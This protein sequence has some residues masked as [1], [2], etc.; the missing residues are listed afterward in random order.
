[1]ANFLNAAFVAGVAVV[2]AAALKL[3]SVTM[4]ALLVV[5]AILAASL[6]A[7]GSRAV[8]FLGQDEQLRVEGFMGVSVRNGPGMKVLNPFSYRSAQV[9]KAES[10]G[11]MDYVKVRDTMTGSERIEQGPRLLFLEPYDQVASRSQAIC[12][13]STD[14]VFVDDKLSG[15]RRVVQGP[16]MWFPGPH[17]Q[18]K[19]GSA[20]SLSRTEYIVV[21]DRLKG[22]RSTVRGPTVWFPG[23]FDVASTK[24]TAIALQEDE[25][26]RLKDCSS[27][28]RWVQK[29]KALV[30]LEPTWQIEGSSSKD[31]GVRKAWSL[32]AYEFIRLVDS[33]TGKVS[34]HRGEM[35][36][37]PGPDEELLD[38]A[39]MNA[40]DLKVQE[41]VKILDQA[42]GEVRVERGRASGSTQV[43]LGPNDKIL[44]GGKK[45]AIEV[46]QDH[47]VLVRDKASGQLRLVTEKAL[48][49]PGPNE[50]IEEV[51][52]LIKLSDHE[53]LIVKDKEGQYNFYYG[54]DEKRG[55]DTPRSFFLPPFAEIVT[56][57]WS[58]GRRRETRDLKISR[59][60]CRAQ[61]MSFEFNCRT[62]DNV[63]LVL[64]G[65]FFWEVVD[66]PAMVKSTGDTSG[67]LCNH[68]RSQ[69]IRHVARVT[70]KQFMDES[71]IIAKKVW[72]EDTEFYASRGVKIHSLEVTRYQCADQSTSE[73]LEQII[74]ETTNRMNRL[75]Q[76]E[77]ENEVS[78]FRTQ[79]QIEQEKMNGELL[80]I[81]HEHSEAEANVNGRAEASR[82]AAFVGGL[83]EAVPRLEERVA[84]WQVLRKTEALSVVSQGGA[85]LYYTPNDVDLSIE[86]KMPVRSSS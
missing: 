67:D 28:Q 52:E 7:L 86:S 64:E 76:A 74:Q 80:K 75:S 83:E 72:E 77:S 12:L 40:I 6:A 68:A 21:E 84:L 61:F 73:I 39:V 29:G 44:D 32:K 22:E 42:S 78:L 1:M 5:L 34:T 20:V 51:R 55:K 23:P 26:M 69:F 41:Y 17:E 31:S 33:V 49:V 65:T 85:S 37:F 8:H 27:G 24:H 50:T 53:A 25:Y 66:L 43:F 4:L 71:H 10:L 16:C 62:S 82:I 48:F 3:V 11:Q 54:S 60:D 81:Q 36:V 63:E 56:L 30:F 58:K 19:Q 79:G 59:F 46:D 70:L 57:V 15:E 38:G 13:G 14:Y 47:A 9:R 35:T 18:A 2:A 45:K